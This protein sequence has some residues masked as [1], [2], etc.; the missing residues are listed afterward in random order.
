MEY[1]PR[2][3]AIELFG[4]ASIKNSSL[5][6]N[7]HELIEKFGGKKMSDKAK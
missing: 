3:I 6:E 4:S 2:D 5:N 1:L 7:V